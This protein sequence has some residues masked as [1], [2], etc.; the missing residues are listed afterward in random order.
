MENVITSPSLGVREFTAYFEESDGSKEAIDINMD[1]GLM[2]YDIF[3]LH[4]CEI[5]KK[6]KPQLSAVS[7]CCRTWHYKCSD[8]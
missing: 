8:I 2:V 1:G 5:R 3:D 4:D 6:V 7:R